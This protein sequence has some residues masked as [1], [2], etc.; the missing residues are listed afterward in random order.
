MC[1]YIQVLNVCACI[2]CMCIMMY[3]MYRYVWHYEHWQVLHVCACILHEWGRLGR[4]YQVDFSVE[5]DC[6]HPLMA[7]E[8]LHPSWLP[9]LISCSMDHQSFVWA[10]I[11]RKTLRFCSC[12]YILYTSGCT[13]ERSVQTPFE[14]A[15]CTS[16]KSIRLISGVYW[17][18]FWVTLRWRLSR[19]CPRQLG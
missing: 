8:V 4:C 6:L 1:R 7:R 10:E 14:L 2:A 11:G 5:M 12:S 3:F 19:F 17:I 9:M 15:T 13:I 18:Q 16:S